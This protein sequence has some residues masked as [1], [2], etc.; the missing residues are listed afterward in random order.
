MTIGVRSMLNYG[1][2][3]VRVKWKKNNKEKAEKKR[4]KRLK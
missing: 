1:V 4:E 3:V 2:M